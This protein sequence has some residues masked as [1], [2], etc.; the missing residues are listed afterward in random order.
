M[1][2][3]CRSFEWRSASRNPC[4]FVPP[5]STPVLFPAGALRSI[6]SLSSTRGRAVQRASQD[7]N[8]SLGRFVLHSRQNIHC[9]E[10]QGRRGT[11][12]EEDPSALSVCSAVTKL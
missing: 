4:P 12:Q 11:N 3:P 9:R 5:D 1:E 10:H 6:L 8:Q 2:K 7:S